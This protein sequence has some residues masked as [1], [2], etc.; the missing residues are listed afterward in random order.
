MKSKRISLSELKRKYIIDELKQNFTQLF[1]LQ[2][3]SERSGKR[4]RSTHAKNQDWQIE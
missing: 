4:N 2:K 3:E 1:E